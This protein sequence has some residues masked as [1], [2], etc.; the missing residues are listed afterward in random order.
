MGGEKKYQD[1]YK[2]T[3]ALYP[4]IH[5]IEIVLRNKINNT[6]TKHSSSW[7]LDFYFYEWGGKGN[8]AKEITAKMKDSIKKILLTLGAK[9][10]VLIIANFFLKRKEIS[11]QKTQK[12][13]LISEIHKAM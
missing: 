5:T 4:A 12:S 11:R 1:Y 6:L 2:I 3:K 7:V 10:I 9:N 13:R 8:F